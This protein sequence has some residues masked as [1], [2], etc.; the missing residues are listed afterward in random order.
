VSGAGRHPTDEERTRDTAPTVAR[1]ASAL[2]GADHDGLLGTLRPDAVWVSP[3]GVVSG[4]PAVAEAVLAAVRAAD[5]WHE[6][7]QSGATAV[8]GFSRDGAPGAL[9]LTVRRDGVV[10]VSGASA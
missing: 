7:V 10:L 4:A 1:V 3:D 6:P 2:R 8:I 5:A 9:S